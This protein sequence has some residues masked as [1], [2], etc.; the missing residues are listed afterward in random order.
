MA[1]WCELRQDF[2]SFRLDRISELALTGEGFEVEAGK[3]LD[4][5]IDRVTQQDRSHRRTP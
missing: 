4:D 1:A 5:F 2:R 3:T